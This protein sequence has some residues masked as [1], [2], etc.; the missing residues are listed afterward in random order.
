MYKELNFCF[1]IFF[2]SICLL[3]V[4]FA[5]CTINSGQFNDC[6][7]VLIPRLEYSKVCRLR[8]MTRRRLRDFNLVVLY[9]HVLD[10]VHVDNNRIIL[11][12]F[13]SVLYFRALSVW[14]EE[15]LNTEWQ[16]I[17]QKQKITNTKISFNKLIFVYIVG[18]EGFFCIHTVHS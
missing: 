3:C 17:K 1:P 15:R 10:A 14:L 13:R 11:K 8:A 4:C 18:N 12:I 5:H 16:H 9:I 7:N 6:Q 2:I